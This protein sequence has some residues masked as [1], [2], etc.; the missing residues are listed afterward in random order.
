MPHSVSWLDRIRIE[1][2][3]WALDQRI[4][5]LPWRT[6]IAHRRE[7]REN[8]LAAAADVGA[9]AALRRLGSS[10]ELARQYLS[11][12]FGDRPR[13]SW[14]AA[15]VFLSGFPLVLNFVL[16][17]ANLGYQHAISAASPHAT[18]IF[19]WSGVSYL[20]HPV[21][22]VFHDGHGSFTGGDYSLIS[23]ALLIAGTVLAGRLW[24][25]RPLRRRTRTRTAAS[26]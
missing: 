11:A 12:E 10:Q 21:V 4:Y 9:G 7:V 24:R 23:W 5:D 17:E 13:H 16:S 19:T 20:Q 8:L 3:V 14:I 22:Y 15:A 1:R 18:G 25:L 2:L 6:R 26:T